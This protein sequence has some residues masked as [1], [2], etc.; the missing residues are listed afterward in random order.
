MEDAGV[1]AAGPNGYGDD[2]AGVA[3][4]GA[5]GP[6]GYGVAGSTAPTGAAKHVAAGP[7]G[8]GIA[9]FE[10]WNLAG[11]GALAVAGA[12]AAFRYQSFARCCLPGHFAYHGLSLIDFARFPLFNGICVLALSSCTNCSLDCFN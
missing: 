1:E 7:N 10:D 2:L 3:T 12:S 11:E 4:K 6:N 8:Y 9:S 5:A